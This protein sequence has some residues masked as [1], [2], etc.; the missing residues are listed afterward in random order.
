MKESLRYAVAAAA[1]NAMSPNTGDFDPKDLEDLL[2]QVAVE[3]I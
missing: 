3:K 1:A 2:E